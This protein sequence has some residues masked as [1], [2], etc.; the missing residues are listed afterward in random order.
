VEHKYTSS[1][2]DQSET[3][4]YYGTSCG[5]REVPPW[6]KGTLDAFR[7][8]RADQYLLWGL[9]Q[10]FNVNSCGLPSWSIAA[11]KS[12]G[13]IVRPLDCCI[14]GKVPKLIE[15]VVWG[16][17]V[18]FYQVNYKHTTTVPT[19]LGQL[20]ARPRVDFPFSPSAR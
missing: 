20:S 2:D 6:G 9:N 19:Y 11:S 14:E 8:N 5:L 15:Y 13:M 7:L 12:G 17:L 16:S 4:I 18:F 1:F 3:T 10:C